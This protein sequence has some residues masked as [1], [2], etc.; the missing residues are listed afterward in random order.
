MFRYVA[1]GNVHDRGPS[2]VDRKPTTYSLSSNKVSQQMDVPLL[3]LAKRSGHFYQRQSSLGQVKGRLNRRRR[4]P[5]HSG[6]YEFLFRAA[7]AHRFR[8]AAAILALPAAEM[9]R[10]FLP[11]ELPLLLT[12]T[13]ALIAPRIPVSFFCNFASSRFSVATMSMDPPSE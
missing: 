2:E 12:P 10:F 3:Q 4:F 9:P 13:R 6:N 8:C 1:R 7:F 5:K 11:V